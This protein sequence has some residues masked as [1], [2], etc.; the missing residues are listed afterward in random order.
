MKKKKTNNLVPPEYSLMSKVISNRNRQLNWINRGLNPGKYPVIKNEDGSYSTHRLEYVT[1]DDGSAF[2]YPTIIQNENGN[3]VNLQDKGWDYAKKT[4]TAIRIP[5]V[6]LADYYS[7]NGLIKHFS[8][9]GTIDDPPTSKELFNLKVNYLINKTKPKSDIDPY[10]KRI[11]DITKPTLDYY[12]KNYIYSTSPSSKG[13][14]LKDTI[15]NQKNN[16]FIPEDRINAIQYIASKAKLNEDSAL[17][18]H[19]IALNEGN[20]GKE[21]DLFNASSLGKEYVISPTD[22]IYTKKWKVKQMESMY[23]NDPET[24]FI[25]FLN[26][27]TGNF[28]D[29]NKYNSAH[30]KEFNESYSDRINRMKTI[31]KANPDFMNKIKSYRKGGELVDPPTGEGERQ[32]MMNWLSNPEATKRMINNANLDDVKLYTTKGIRIKEVKNPT[33]EQKAGKVINMAKGKV[34]KAGIEYKYKPNADWGGRY[35]PDKNKIEI[36]TDDDSNTSNVISHEFGH[37]ANL[38]PVFSDFINKYNRN[39]LPIDEVYSDI[40]GLRK[41]INIQPGQVINLNTINKLRNNND[42]MFNNDRL[43]NNFNN[44]EIMEL[45]NGLSVKSNNRQ[46]VRLGGIIKPKR[47]AIGGIISAASGLYD[48]GYN[49]GNSMVESNKNEYGLI[50][51]NTAHANQMQAN[52]VFDPA[53][54]IATVFGSGGSWEDLGYWGGKKAAAEDDKKY[55][56]IKAMEANA[57]KQAKLQIGRYGASTYNQYGYP[58]SSMYRRGGKTE[59]PPGGTLS[60]TEAYWNAVN[61]T[62]ENLG[63]DATMWKQVYSRV[64]K[65]RPMT[66]VISETN[67]YNLDRIKNNKL[68][69]EIPLDL[70]KKTTSPHTMSYNKYMNPITIWRKLGNIFT[71]EGLKALGKFGRNTLNVLVPGPEQLPVIPGAMP[72]RKVNFGNT[73]LKCGGKAKKKIHKANGGMIPVK[74]DNDEIVYDA[75]G[76]PAPII[77]NSKI[78]MK[79]G[80]THIRGG[81]GGTDKVNAMLPEGAIVISDD[82]GEKDKLVKAFNRNPSKQVINTF[83]NRAVVK[84]KE[85]KGLYMG[86]NPWQDIDPMGLAKTKQLYELDDISKPKLVGYGYNTFNPSINSNPYQTQ[87][88]RYNNLATRPVTQPISTKGPAYIG[89][90]NPGY[91]PTLSK[92]PTFKTTLLSNYTPSDNI[93]NLD[94]KYTWNNNGDRLIDDLD[95]NPQSVITDDFQKQ[96]GSS[97]SKSKSD[98]NLKTFLNSDDALQT[99]GTVGELGLGIANTIVNINAYNK[100]KK[101][102]YYKYTPGRYFEQ[103]PRYMK[104]FFNETKSGLDQSSLNSMEGLRRNIS[105]GSL[106]NYYASLNANLLKNKSGL[107]AQE[108]ATIGDILNKNAAGK[109]EFY[110]TEAIRKMYYD[111]GRMQHKMGLINTK[112][113]LNQNTINTLQGFT[114][115]LKNWG[116]QNKQLAYMRDALMLPE[117]LPGETMEEYRK[118]SARITLGQQ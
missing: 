35:Y 14:T 16:L 71:S 13:I 99:I 36:N 19:A 66:T 52:L 95:T 5:N 59:D 98:N 112:L 62:E 40:F 117:R 65:D 77:T 12:N 37:A 29:L 113:A 115:N 118:R 2:V 103:D 92:T 23:K 6:K 97:I 4:N 10:Q 42:I 54:H 49:L 41:Q 111:A 34:S 104:A 43:F 38:S 68:S 24:N 44:N 51:N 102:P 101:L 18:L 105:G 17:N 81:K 88:Y 91:T 15:Y 60:R 57:E 33:L 50:D 3:L 83:M 11:N 89:I 28:K 8:F 32:W 109:S 75:N 108:S 63:K 78:G 116:Y 82:N 96:R 61:G 85:G 45:M 84:Q 22:D 58:T 39:K 20:Y 72:D 69:K 21:G 70:E 31:I 46:S 94:N 67:N 106:G 90:N 47:R 87:W 7:K 86:G 48:M 107:A 74:L 9:G 110:N 76:N 100:L 30:S 73:N 114:N 26:T 64:Y 55:A 79:A 80:G 1:N 93:Y 53:G 25:N 27:Q 56:K